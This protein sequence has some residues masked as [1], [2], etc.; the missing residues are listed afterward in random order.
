MDCHSGFLRRRLVRHSDQQS[1]FWTTHQPEYPLQMGLQ[2]FPTGNRFR[3]ASALWTSGTGSQMQL[4]KLQ[5]PA[6]P[7]QLDKRS[8]AT[9]RRRI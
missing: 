3:L 8:E 5:R 4:D 6:G 1:N 2:H 9:F 7:V